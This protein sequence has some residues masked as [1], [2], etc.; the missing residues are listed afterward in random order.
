MR[1]ARLRYRL[2]LQQQTATKDSYGAAIITWST[3]KTVWGAIEPLTGWESFS[4]DQVNSAL[5]V[6][7]VIRYGSGWSG[8]NSKW[9]IEDANTGR[10]YGINSVIQPDQRTRP[11]T[12]IELMCTES[13]A[14]DQ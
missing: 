13:E 2:N 3:T 12:V 9:R 1:S 7:I 11:N 4:A 5:Q 14:D 10:K 8:I 6:R